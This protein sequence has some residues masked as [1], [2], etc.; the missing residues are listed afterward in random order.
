MKHPIDTAVCDH[1]PA[2]IIAQALRTDRRVLLAGQPGIGKSTLARKLAAALHQDGRSCCCIGADPGSPRFGLPGTVCLARWDGKGWHSL[3]Y[4]AVCTFDAGRFRLPLTA[5][6]RRLSASAPASTLLIDGPGLVRGVAAAELLHALAEVTEVDLVLAL[7]RE[8]GKRH[9]SNELQALGAEVRW[10]LAAPQARRP[11]QRPRARHRTALWDNYLQAAEPESIDLATLRLLGT[12]PPLDVP[13]AWANRQI[14]LLEAGRTVAMGEATALQGR[15]LSI[16]TPPWQGRPDALLIRDAMRGS[17]GYLSTAQPFAATTLTYLPPQDVLPQQAGEECG[18]PRPVVRTG[19]ADAILLNGVYGDPL[20]HL[21]LRQQRRSLLFDLGM[22]GRLSARLAH[23]VTDVFI[24]HAH[25]DHIGGFLWL[26]RSRIG[27]LPPCRIYGPPGLA[28]HI[29]GLVRGVHWD[30]IGERGPS[31]E[32]NE[33]RTG[34][35]IRSRIQAGRANPEHLAEQPAANGV[36]L[37]E[38]LFQVRA[39]TL[40][41]GIPVLAFAFEPPFQIRIRKDRLESHR[42]AAGAWLGKLKAHLLAGNRSALIDLP[43]GTR[44]PA[45]RLGDELTLMKPGRKL[46]YATDLADTADNRRRLIRLARDGH[47]LFCEAAFAEADAEQALRTGHLT[48]R[49]CGEI[50]T[51]ANV[52]QLI[53]FHF[54]RRYARDLAPLYA[55]IAAVCSRLVAPV[56][57]GATE[58]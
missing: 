17:D 18:G 5:A 15:R 52:N 32:V 1:A 19:L 4:E 12:P 28:E 10:V 8:G 49:A 30:R 20:L 35:L 51:T 16:K 40:D 6:V 25:I 9:L 21:R 45:G 48:T 41:H 37:S 36:L 50:A 44:A 23:Q 14:A 54:S 34:Q 24:S 2:D 27:D 29:A 3:A 13:S 55:E 56:L 7:V 43:D 11:G 53:P 42:G 33:L 31:F 58:P 22:P 26:L 39:T 38:P 47:A 57:R 46:V